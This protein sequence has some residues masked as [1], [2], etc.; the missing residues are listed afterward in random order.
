MP[1]P[2]FHYRKSTPLCKAFWTIH[3]ATRPAYGT[4]CHLLSPHLPIPYRLPLH[5]FFL[6]FSNLHPSPQS[7]TDQ[8]TWWQP[9]PS[10]HK[11]LQRKQAWPSP[12]MAHLFCFVF[13]QANMPPI[14]EAKMIARMTQQIMIMIFFCSSR[15]GKKSTWETVSL[16]RGFQRTGDEGGSGRGSRCEGKGRWIWL[17]EPRVLREML[18]LGERCK[19]QINSELRGCF[20]CCS[21][22][23]LPSYQIYA[24]SPQSQILSVSQLKSSAGGDSLE[25]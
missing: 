19:N 20:L 25:I 12:Q 13:F 22:F 8:G 17:L 18:L 3:S 9:K 1:M 10:G 4:D 5:A 21:T 6:V 24:T 14:V 11:R 15:Q 23:Q 16:Q 2:R 7:H